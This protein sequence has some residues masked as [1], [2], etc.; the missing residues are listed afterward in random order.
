M[1]IPHL[2]LPMATAAHS[3]L[4]DTLI[5]Q[6]LFGRM[7]APEGRYSTSQ[8]LPISVLSAVRHATCSALRVGEGM[9]AMWAISVCVRAFVQPSLIGT[10]ATLWLSNSMI[11]TY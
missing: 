6:L 9:V 10:N 8:F 11:F 4:C 7:G 2:A 1:S 3:A 5:S